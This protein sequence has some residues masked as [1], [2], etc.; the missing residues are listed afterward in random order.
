MR[1]PLLIILALALGCAFLA[2]PAIAK[3]VQELGRPK[4]EFAF[5]PPDCPDNCQAV[6]QVT[7]FQV[8]LG[9]AHNPFRARRSGY[10]TAFTIRLS[11]PNADQIS[12]FKTT[13]CQG[14]DPCDGTPRV[15]LAIVRSLHHAHEYKL[16]KQTQA[17]SMEPY[18]GSTPTIALRQPFRVKK[19]DIVAIT[20]PTWLPAFSHN[21]S[22]DQAWRSSHSED[23]CVASLPPTAAQEEEGT[24]KAYECFYRTARL[25]YSATFVGDPKPTNVAATR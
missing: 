21:Q 18:L 4:G 22:S 16:L 17:F 1:R 14:H 3:N 24:K 7:G 10:V 25:L 2:A 15:R 19:E 8:Q 13:Y 5:P 12:F 11:K 9:D 20:V 23:E 6:A